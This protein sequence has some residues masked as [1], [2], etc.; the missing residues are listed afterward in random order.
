MKLKELIGISAL[1]L[2]MAATAQTTLADFETDAAYTKLGVYDTWP[3]SPFR[4][5]KLAGNVKVVK[6]HLA[7]IDDELGKVVNP[8]GHILAVQRSRYG[9]NTFGA[10]IDLKEPLTISPTTQYVHALI[11]KPVEG[12]AMLVG[13]GK[14]TERAGQS[15]E[16]EQFWVLSSTKITPDK[17]S[18]AVFAV[19]G[20]SGIEIHSLVIIPDC[21]RTDSLD[22]D[23]AAYID[24]ITIS[25][26]AL[27]RV[28]HG[29]YPLNFDESQTSEKSGN[30]IKSIALNG[31]ADG[32]QSITIGSL[33][34]QLIYRPMLEKSF[35]AKAGETLTPQFSFSANWMNG[36]VYL[37]RGNDGKFTSDLNDNYTIPDGSDIMSYSY[38][39]TVEN[40]SGYTSD[41]TEVTGGNRNILNPPAFTLPSDLAIGFYRMRFKVDWGNVDPAGNSSASQSI[42]KNGGMIVDVRMNIHGD[43]VTLSRDGG[44][45]GDL[46]KED[47]N[48]L[49]SETVPFGKS[50]TVIAKPAPGF[51]LSSL[52]V[53]HGYNLTGDSLVHGTPQYLDIVYHARAFSDNKFTIPAEVIDGDV[54]LIPEFVE[55]NGQALDEDYALNFDEDLAITRTD[56]H[57]NSFTVV[58]ANGGTT[59]VSLDNSGT[60]NVYRPMLSK[61]VSVMPGDAVNISVDY[62]GTAMHNYLYVDLNQDGYFDYTLNAD[63]T[64]TTNGELLAYT[65][66]DGKNSLGEAITTQAGKVS[67]ASIPTFTI[68]AD[69]AP[70]MYRARLKV[71][72]NNIDPAGQWSE[73]GSNQINENGGYVVDFLLNVHNAS[74]KLDLVTSNGS[75][76][77]SGNTGTEATI[78][79]LTGVTLLPVPATTGYA[80]SSVAI[81]HGHNLDG[82]Q[83]IH[84][85]RQWSEYS[86]K[87]NAE[88]TIPAD[89]VNGELRVTAH[90]M[91]NSSAKLGL[92]F[93][94][95]FDSADGSL[96]DGSKWVRSPFGHGITW[97]RF[98]A[99][100]AEGQQQT[101]YIEDGNLVLLCKP[102]TLTSEV[103]ANRAQKEMISGAVQT[104]G[105]F[106][107]RYGKL[108]VRLLNEPYRGNFPAVWMMPTDNSAGWPTCGEID[109]WETID[110]SSTSY[111][112]IHSRWANSTSDGATCQGQSNN[113][114]KSGTGTAQGGKYHVFGL[115]WTEDLLSW[116]VDGKKVFSYAK[117]T[118]QDALDLGQWPFNKRFYLIINQ[119]VGKGTWAASPDVTH[120]YRMLVD[121]VRVYTTTAKPTDIEEAETTSIE[122]AFDCY[123]RAG[124]IIIVAASEQP[125]RIVDMQGRTVFNELVQ[126]NKSIT[127]P[128]GV[129]VAGGKKLIVH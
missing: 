67:T 66:F 65:Y 13:L 7:G 24:D 11:H 121:W 32:N 72:W 125:V 31:S 100:T 28:L 88:F 109:V 16:T 85:N 49:Q 108:E 98:N 47:G 51:K 84:G 56:R 33:S 37:D 27:P 60:N 129:Y 69:L 126:G 61:E 1:A 101:G 9:S 4:T 71:D 94:D 18:D 29:D 39:E 43:N 15:K 117:S 3:E 124:K 17:W 21:E 119:S 10:R 107:F 53:R 91:P 116:Y 58:A 81:R 50:Y 52:R 127:L 113:P 115:E 80:A 99:S 89:S 63:G 59:K 118:S 110:A 20:Q 22:A 123:V 112:T 128:Q 30:Y 25:S 111:H 76:V 12:R 77:G 122:Q 96:P 120:T 68:P 2:P 8:S 114:A 79:Y 46:L 48:I 70:G 45:N 6:N 83:Y 74:T 34:P 86:V 26:S 54:Y 73:G 90:F 64:P 44:L 93:Y 78:D 40:T 42:A 87:G 95:E 92:K 19:R 57:L 36:Y 35:K 38:V 97:S 55:D 104:N 103:D 62:T 106:N 75:L 102:N 82:E 14:R 105:K 5:D 23:F 41:G